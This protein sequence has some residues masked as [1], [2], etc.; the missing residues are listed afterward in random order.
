LR[1]TSLGDTP[2]IK[3]V[4]PDWILLSVIRRFRPPTRPVFFAA[5]QSGTVRSTSSSVINQRR[6]DANRLGFAI[7]MC[8]LRYPGRALTPGELAPNAL[9]TMVARQLGLDPNVWGQYAE[10]EET[11]RE[12]LSELRIFLGLT[13]FGLKQF[14][15]SI[16]WLAERALQTDK[17]IVLATA[18]VQELR[19]EK[20]ILPP[21]KVIE[22][23]CALAMTR[24]NRFALMRGRGD[25]RVRS[26]DR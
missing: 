16:R 20:R 25:W 21:L 11:R 13:P 8:S 23:I 18:L 22:R 1:A 12:H 3:R 7:L 24:A 4:F 17:G 6:G 14:H 15:E 19:Q 26:P 9:L 10:R 2:L 5:N